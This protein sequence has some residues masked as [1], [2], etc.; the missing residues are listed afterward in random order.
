[1]DETRQFDFLDVVTIMA[2][3][4][5][6]QGHIISENQPT[7]KQIMKKLNYI[8]SILEDYAPNTLDGDKRP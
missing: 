8:I 3:G 2:L 4:F 1:M 5:Q 6:M 7:N